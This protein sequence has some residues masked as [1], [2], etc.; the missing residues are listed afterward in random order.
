MCWQCAVHAELQQLQSQPELS[1]VTGPHL[2]LTHMA[3]YAPVKQI[4]A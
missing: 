1:A 3:C 2:A 4:L